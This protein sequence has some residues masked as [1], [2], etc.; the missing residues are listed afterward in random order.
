MKR[1][2]SLVLLATLCLTLVPAGLAEEAAEYQPLYT[3]AEPYGFKLGGAFGAG[4]MKNEA[5]LNMLKQDFNS[6]TC[7]NEMKAYSM[8]DQFGSKNT[9][10]GMPM[11][12]FYWADKMVEWV[13]QN[14]IKV[15]GHVLVWDAYM[16]DWF[17]REGYD[18]AKP[19][20]DRETMLKRM[21]YYIT[22][23]IT[24]FETKYPGVVYCWDVVNEAV[25][26]N[27]DEFDPADPRH[28]RKTRN[29]GPNL[30]YELVGD[31]YVEYSFLYARNAVDALGADIKLFY[32]DYNAFF[33]QK[34]TAMCALAESVNSFATDE[35]GNP[36]KLM[37]GMGM[38]GYIGGYGYQ[39]GCL[40]ASHLSNIRDSIKA[41]GDLGLEVHI[42]EMAVRNFDP[43]LTAE[44][45]EYYGKLFE[46]FKQV[47]SGDVKPLTCVAIWGMTDRPN[48]QKG[49]YNYNLISPYGGLFTEKFE[50]KDA[51][52]NVYNTLLK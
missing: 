45:A 20:V 17:F 39:D 52:M 46:I 25:G 37:D 26:D 48:E 24:H 5:H 27:V 32:N 16:C 35:N 30:F 43:E 33:L 4:D 47:N 9:K 50:R 44:H 28:L 31:D 22:E 8:L 14:N 18:S 1:L 3:L 11:I 7:T 19:Y 6:V 10:D 2:I 36:R 12:N 42:T 29:G 13:Q 49:T 15:R 38:Q 34:R 41:Y 40:S 23:V 21:E 51:W